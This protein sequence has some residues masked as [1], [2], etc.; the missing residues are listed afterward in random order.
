MN[1][2]FGNATMTH[3]ILH[4]SRLHA[5]PHMN[6]QLCPQIKPNQLIPW[7]RVLPEKLAVPQTVKKFPKFYGTQ[8]FTTTITS[9]CHLSLSWAWSIQSMPAQPNSWR[10]ILIFY[11]H[12]YL[13]PLNSPFP[14]GQSTNNLHA[15]LL[16][17]IHATCPT[18]LILLHKTQH[19]LNNFLSQLN[20]SIVMWH[21]IAW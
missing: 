6:I 16:S 21:H 3:Q 2:V 14:S 19:N 18:H 17:P 8:R 7:S 10:S 4:N 11:S 15:P 9:T 12:L 13:G 1:W 20:F 5:L